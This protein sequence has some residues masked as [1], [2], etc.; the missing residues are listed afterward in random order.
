[1]NFITFIVVQQ[2]SQPGFIPFPSQAPSISP[3]PHIYYLIVKHCNGIEQHVRNIVNAS[4]SAI[5]V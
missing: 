5:Q 2:S 3:T 4:N 1:M